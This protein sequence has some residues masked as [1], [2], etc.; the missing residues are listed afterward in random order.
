M[1][2]QLAIGAI[3][4]E[5]APFL[6]EWLNFHVGIGITHF[7]LY[8]NYSTDDFRSVLKPWQDAGFVTLTEWPVEVG[9]IPAYRDCLRRFKNQARWIAFIDV[10]EFLFAP[11]SRNL[12]PTLEA[13]AHLP[14]IEVWQIFFG[15]NGHVQRPAAPVIEAY[16]R[17]APANPTTV[18]SI[19]NP[20]LVYKP[21]VHQFKYWQ[22]HGR[23]TAGQIV[24]RLT[25]PVFEVLRINHYWSRSLA[26]LRT[27]VR[28]GDAS[29]P[30]KR[31]LDWHLQFERG[32]NCETDLTIQPIAR[33]NSPT[34]TRDTTP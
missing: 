2:Y 11:R 4:R 23:D 10:D 19:V 21:G 5:E 13:F 8:N 26:D 22:G 12:L 18:K 1:R 15:A 27:K 25:P 34:M 31:D 9:Q 17:C 33:A 7:Y 14:G 24:D 3:F 6:E 32:L 30:V 20:R 16:T 29:T 28:R